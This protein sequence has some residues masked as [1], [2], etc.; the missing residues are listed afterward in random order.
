MK[1]RFLWVLA[2][3]ALVGIVRPFELVAQPNHLVISQ[4]YAGAGC[5]TPGCSLYQNDFIEIFN[6]TNAPVN[7]DGWSVQYAGSSGQT[8]QVTFLPNFNL[9]PGQYYLIGQFF[10]AN[11]V[12]AL[13]TP[14]VTGT[15]NM[16][17]TGGRVALLNAT[18]ALNGSCPTSPSIIDL[19]GYGMANCSETTRS[20]AM[21]LTT[22]LTRKNGGC[23]DT[24]NNLGD[25]ALVTAAPRNSSTVVNLCPIINISIND[26]SVNEGNSGTTLFNFTVSLSAPAPDGGVF[27][28]IATANN[29]ATTANNDYVARSLVAQTIPAGSSTY[30]FTVTVNGDAAI[31]S[32][33]TFFVN[34]SS[35]VGA[36]VIDD[37][38]IGTILTDDFAG[39]TIAMIQGN[40]NSSPLLNQ[41]VFVQG[42]VTGVKSNGFFL[43]TPDERIDGDPATSE[44]IYVFTSTAP[45]AAAVVG[46]EVLVVGTVFEFIPSTDVSS[47]SLTEITSPTSISLLSTGNPLP[48][49]VLISSADLLANSVNNLERFEGM[50][51]QVNSVTCVAPTSGNM[52][53]PTATVISNGYF[54]GVITG[55]ARPFREAGVRVPDPLP[56]GAPATVPRWD[57]NP[58]LLGID[59]KSLAGATV[60]NVSTGAVVTGITGPLDYTRRYYTVLVDPG[61]SPG[62]SNNNRAYTSARMAGSGEVSIASINL[63]RFYDVIDDIGSSDVALTG[64]AYNNRLAKASLTI[65]NVLNYPDVIGVAEVEKLSVLQDIA[66]KVNTD[67]VAA[68]QANPN[69]VAYLVEGNDASGLDIGLL[70][71]SSKIST[72]G[73]SQ[74]GALATYVNPNTGISET[75]F[76]RPPLVLS[77]QITIAG[78]ASPVP[79][80][81]MMNSLRNWTSIADVPEGIRVRQ[82]RKSQAEY[83]AN[84]LQT[85]QAADATERIICVGDFNAFQMNDG[86]VDLMGTIKGSPTAASQVVAS[87]ADLVNPD[88]IL[89][90]DSL[91]AVERYTYISSGTAHA[92]DHILVSSSVAARVAGYSIARLGTDF[93]LIYYG[94]NSRP[95]GLT[96]HDVPVVFLDLQC[97]IPS[98]PTDYFRTRASGNWNS[99]ATWE[100][101]ADGINWH[102]ATLVPDATANTIS[103]LSGH[104]VVVTANV[105]VDQLI[106]STGANVTVNTGVVFTIL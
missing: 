6:P 41:A 25:F 104:T 105:T 95:E 15:I 39:T 2:V 47:P 93:P 98:A 19:L 92:Q 13:P 4:V 14:D 52:T 35:V 96:D 56:V 30:T 77:A 103:I 27:F 9:Q 54:Y 74:I 16:L 29:T 49:P 45:P 7:L 83:V 31:E 89:L 42:I 61:V 84:Y 86:Y 90:A 75:L 99:I 60:L 21:G 17:E 34:L 37:Q 101:S 22:S 43:Q 33:E 70:I 24:D 73:V 3:F 78:C 63:Q 64:T 91:P 57:G 5:S 18:T 55:T 48:A 62:V 53:E 36:T 81:V 44:G 10:S 71:K 32:T 1:K 23:R 51:V 40:G 68:S 12:N 88:F 58:E 72:L 87:S 80:T 65:R 20:G 46:N 85:R 94:D 76:D 67:A 28:A 79:F 50:R 26:V 38:G 106:V 82:K 102:A 97:S 69:Y 66:S 59:T 8:W 11:G 100:S